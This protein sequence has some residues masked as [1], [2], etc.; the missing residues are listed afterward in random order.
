MELLL[1]KY[2]GLPEELSS[3]AGELRVLI[4]DSQLEVNMQKALRTVTGIQ[5]VL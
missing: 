3:A 5:L 2:Y 1:E 4:D